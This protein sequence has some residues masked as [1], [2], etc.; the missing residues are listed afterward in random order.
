M[1]KTISD[2][3]KKIDELDKKILKLIQERVN[4]A[5]QIRHLKIKQELPLVTPDRE[6]KLIQHLIRL[7]NERLPE[8]VIRDIWESII[9]GGKQTGDS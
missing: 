9:E 3:R 8:Q 2:H 5:I 7:S 4:E 1:K 6:E